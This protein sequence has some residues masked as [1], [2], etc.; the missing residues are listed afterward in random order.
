ALR[1]CD[2]GRVQC[3]LLVRDDFWLAI[4]RFMQDLEVPLVDGQNCAAVERFDPLHA[5][6]VLAEFG[7]AY[8]RLPPATVPLSPEQ[9]RFLE[10]AVEGLREG[11]SVAPVRLS[12]FTEMV[13]GRRWDSE[14]LKQVGGAR[15]VGVA[16]LEDR[17]GR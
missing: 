12:L 9:E 3:L 2:G 14:T 16:F 6:A 8:T 11:E 1:Q 13:K 15:G 4:G 5:R 10:E 17:L 7:R